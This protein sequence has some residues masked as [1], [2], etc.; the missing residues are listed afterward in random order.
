M[1]SLSPPFSA[2]CST[3]EQGGGGGGGA[4]GAGPSRESRETGQPALLHACLKNVN[5][6]N[7]NLFLRLKPQKK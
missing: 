6:K 7:K 1:K 2:F 3:R 4:V 5:N